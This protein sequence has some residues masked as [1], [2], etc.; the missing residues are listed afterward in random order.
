MTITGERRRGL[1]EQVAIEREWEKMTKTHEC[2]E[3]RGPLV[4]PHD[5]AVGHR[6]LVCGQDRSHHGFHRVGSMFE[7]WKRGE[8]VPMYVADHFRKMK[9]A[10]PMDSKA[11]AVMPVGT[12]L[13]R[14]EGV[15]FP[16][17]MTTPQRLMLAQAAITYTLDP[18][19]GELTLYQGHLYVSIDGRYRKAQETGLLA[20]VDTRPATQKERKDWDIPDADYFFRSEVYVKDVGRPFVGWGRV[21]QVETKPP[22]DPRRRGYRPLETN[23]QRMAEKRAEAQALRKAFHI[24]LPSAEAI[25]EEGPYPDAIEGEAREIPEDEPERQVDEETGEVAEPTAATDVTRSQEA[26]R[27]D[28][29]QL[30]PADLPMKTLG[31]LFNACHE[32]FGLKKPDVYRILNVHDATEIA[33]VGDAWAIVRAHKLEPEDVAEE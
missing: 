24:P 14:I 27:D 19:M 6:I 33:D 29:P 9:G 26:D 22:A 2:A 21:R 15:K 13:E 16:Q 17:E 20:G 5:P 10:E 11:L 23:P 31:D 32:H 12:M 30:P 18:V 3:C 7:R 8:E 4:M 1:Y 28:A 25:G